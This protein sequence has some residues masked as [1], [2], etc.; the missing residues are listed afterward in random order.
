MPLSSNSLC[1]FSCTSSS[2][3]PSIRPTAQWGHQKH[4]H[5]HYA[6]CLV[7]FY[8]LANYPMCCGPFPPG[9]RS[10]L[11]LLSPPSITT[12]GKVNFSCVSIFPPPL[13]CDDSQ[14]SALTVASASK[15]AN[16][17]L[18]SRVKIIKEYISTREGEARPG[19]GGGGC[20]CW[21]GC[22][23]V[24]LGFPPMALDQSIK[25]TLLMMPCFS[26]CCVKGADHWANNI[27]PSLS[28]SCH[29]PHVDSRH[30]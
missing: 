25:H 11:T 6:S 30:R 5:N 26:W 3:S 21:L 28:V 18:T 7:L 1:S 10:L 29:L 27:F 13:R 16:L 2:L 24:E 14:L 17:F 23:K 22:V 15:D 8:K 12:W 19:K 9:A 20:M 4:I